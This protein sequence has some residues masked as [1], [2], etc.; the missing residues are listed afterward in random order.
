MNISLDI[1]TVNMPEYDWIKRYIR[2]KAEQLN[3]IFPQISKCSVAIEKIRRD[4]FKGRPYKIRLNIDTVSGYNM[5]ICTGQREYD[6]DKSLRDLLESAFNEALGY[7]NEFVE[8][9]RT[10]TS[11]ND[12]IYM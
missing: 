4:Q 11:L 9:Q 10:K 3:E 8:R 1:S 6:Y 5:V 12:L 2:M 7:L